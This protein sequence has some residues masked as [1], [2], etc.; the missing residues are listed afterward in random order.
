[1]LRLKDYNENGVAMADDQGLRRRQFLVRLG[2][3]A[4]AA[5][6]VQAG[7][8][9]LRPSGA[10]SP[11]LTA[12]LSKLAG[13]KG[14]SSLTPMDAS[15]SELPA[16]LFGE[17]DLGSRLGPC[18]LVSVSDVHLGAIAVQLRDP[19]GE[20]FQVDIVRRETGLVATRGI[21]NTPSLSLFLVNGGDGR[22]LSREEHGLGAMAL[23]A[24]LTHREQL[25]AA[26]PRLLT[27]RER[28]AAFLK[29]PSGAL[30]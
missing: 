29:D 5:A 23:G 6:A 26:V 27:L 20:T 17:I 21:A 25:G 4:G 7:M 1:M 12:G 3:V 10:A 22:T 30:V 16:D 8:V 18:T 28:N 15:P 11:T 14:D 13:P 9:L 19:H 2:Y 24:R